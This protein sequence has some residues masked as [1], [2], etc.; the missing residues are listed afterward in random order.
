MAIACEHHD[1]DDHVHMNFEFTASSSI[2]YTYYTYIL[3]FPQILFVLVILTA[4]FNVY[5]IL[6][7]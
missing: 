2:S 4:M 1:H 6:N 5:I 3:K 7:V